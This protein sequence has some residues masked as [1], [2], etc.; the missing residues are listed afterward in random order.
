M[1]V[2]HIQLLLYLINV[3]ACVRACLPMLHDIPY[4]DCCFLCQS[5]TK[6]LGAIQWR[7]H[8]MLHL[9]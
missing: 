7:C 2:K 1:I 4:E 3:H 6:A 9:M 5:A 8:A